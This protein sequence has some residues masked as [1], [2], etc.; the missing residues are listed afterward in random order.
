MSLLDCDKNIKN[1]ENVLFENFVINFLKENGYIA[2]QTDYKI[3][4]KKPSKSIFHTHKYWLMVKIIDNN[5]YIKFAKDYDKSN[6]GYKNIYYN[7]F[8]FVVRVSLYL[9]NNM[10]RGWE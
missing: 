1:F 10:F 2:S 5:M 3:I 7:D 9:I 6:D 4:V 8:G